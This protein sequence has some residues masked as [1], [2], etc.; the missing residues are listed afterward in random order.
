MMVFTAL[1]GVLGGSNW[2]NLFWVYAVG[3]VI[4]LMGFFM[5]PK[6]VKTARAESAEKSDTSEKQ[7]CL[8]LWPVLMVIP[9]LFI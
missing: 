4:F 6:E 7:A 9:G 8:R 5:I 2:R 1:G 3:V